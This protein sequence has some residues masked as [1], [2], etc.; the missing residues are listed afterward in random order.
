MAKVDIAALRKRLEQIGGNSGGKGGKFNRW[1]YTK[2]GTYHLR[3]LP[4][5]NAEPGMPFPLR[6][7]Y[8]GINATGGGMIVSP[9]NAGEKDPIKDFRIGLYNQAKEQAP[10]QAEETKKMAAL[11]KEKSVNSV[12]IV[13]R[14][15]EDA[16]PQMWSPNYT[17]VK[18]LEGLFLTDAGDYTDVEEGCDITLVVT[19]GKK[20][21][22][23]GKRRGEPVLE[24]TITADRKNTPAHKDPAVVKGWLENMPDVDAYYPVTSTEETAKKLQEWIDAGA[25]VAGSDGTSRGGKPEAK[26]EAKDESAPAAAAK[27]AEKKA[28]PA[29]KPAPAKKSLLENVADDMDRELDDLETAAG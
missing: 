15:N 13:D 1:S 5:A 19:A 27:P 7:V 26:D 22:Q 14:S 4:F 12:A 16:G 9:E 29:P 8:Y 3:V 20:I 18:Q 21:V 11:L 28:T 25:N 2:P 17:D 24:A 6:I 10:A 23:S